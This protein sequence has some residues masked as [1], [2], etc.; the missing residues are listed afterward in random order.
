MAVGD[1]T[2]Q[3][4][5]HKR[6]EEMMSGGTTVVLVSHSA[7]DVRRICQKAAWIDKS[8]LRFVGD[9]NEALELYQQG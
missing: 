5:C 7:E 1:Q 9:V 3:N 2:F 4:K 8:Y 6:M